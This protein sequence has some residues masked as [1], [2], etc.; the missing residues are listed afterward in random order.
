MKRGAI[1]CILTLA[2]AITWSAL[3]QPRPPSES[4]LYM[5]MTRS[6]VLRVTSYDA[7]IDEAAQCRN[8][9][10]FLKWGTLDELLRHITSADPV[11]LW[12]L[13]AQ[14]PTD[15]DL[16]IVAGRAAWLIEQTTGST[17]PTVSRESLGA[18]R[19]RIR[20]AAEQVVAAYK[21]GIM[22]A[23]QE[24]GTPSAERV[25]ELTRLYLGQIKTGIW[26]KEAL[27]YQE[28]FERVLAEWFPLGKRYADLVTIVGPG[29]TQDDEVE[30]RFDDGITGNS[31]HLRL[32]DG[33]IVSVELRAGE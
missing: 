29:E 2:L 20:S 8:G 28:R 18:N 9:S 17:L 21:A 16:Q 14:R 7:L 32:K 4:R 23:G 30:Y 11:P 27:V 10:S 33:V 5:G 26:D 1:V 19:A 22:Q 25:R 12:V 13:P 6:T 24:Y 31:Y 3:A 15:H